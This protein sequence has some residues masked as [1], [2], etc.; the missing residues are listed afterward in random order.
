MFFTDVGTNFTLGL[1]FL[2]EGVYVYGLY[3]DGA[4]W[5]KRNSR[6]VESL[7]KV[8]FVSLPIVHVTA[9]NSTAPKDPKLYQV[10]FE[11]NLDTDTSDSILECGKTT[12]L[13]YILK[14]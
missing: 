7:S 1:W 5:D 3:V 2:Q 13:N 8:L 12:L 10:N 6:L 14:S 4:G 9:I 11:E